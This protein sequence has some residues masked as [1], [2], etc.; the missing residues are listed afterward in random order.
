[1]TD[2]AAAGAAAN[3]ATIDRHHLAELIKRERSLYRANFPGSW[4]AFSTAGEHLLGG[5]PMTWMRMWSGGY[6][7]FHAAASGARLIDIDGNEFI[8][9]CLGDTGAMAG[10]SPVAVQE[11]LSRRYGEAG[12]ATTMLPT[13][14]AAWVAGELTRRFGAA[15]WSFTLTATDANRW[16]IRLARQATGRQKILV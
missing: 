1:M 3:L 7:I 6:P 5:V 13:Q 4:E 16:A 2:T 10:H 11:A 14:D 15:R 9:F 12:G 8:D